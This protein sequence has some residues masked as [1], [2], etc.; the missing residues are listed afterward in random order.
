M[1]REGI[2]ILLRRI[3]SIKAYLKDPS[4]PKIKKFLLIFGIIYLLSPIDLIPA[5]VLGFS[6]I[7]DAVL[8]A[9]I[10]SYLAEELD[11]YAEAEP[12]TPSFSKA[13]ERYQGK[14]IIEVEAT[15][16]E[17]DED[18]DPGGTV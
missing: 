10:L 4:A 16:V 2:R 17:D 8:W 18:V 6:L 1:K 12:E 9:A 7:D 15:V 13:E 5:P 14:K 3:K 11:R